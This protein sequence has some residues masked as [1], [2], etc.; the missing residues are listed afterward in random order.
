M[1]W[2]MHILH[3][4]QDWLLEE[5]IKD[6]RR[7]KIL[8]EPLPAHWDEYLQGNVAFYSR[9][10]PDNQKQLHD[11]L[12]VFAAERRWEGCGGLSITD[13]IKVT[14]AAQAC[15]L[16]LGMVHDYFSQVSSILVY[17]SGFLIDDAYSVRPGVI[18]EEGVAAIG[19][20]WHRGP[21]VLAWDAV[22][23]NGRDL[24]AGRNVVY[25]EFAHQLDFQGEW[26]HKTSRAEMA[27]LGKHWN[28]VMRREFERLV[29]A[30]EEGRA[31]LLDK[32]G[33]ASPA[34]F[35][36]V[37][38]ECFFCNP[39]GLKLRHPRLYELLGDFYGQDPAKWYQRAPEL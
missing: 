4:V 33:T 6:R 10:P 3:T 23:A 1:S 16:L 25:H 26:P 18:H 36:A 5:P 38:T 7:A 9:L 35:F 22:L 37:A 11:T 32:Y 29:R 24:K 30:S 2:W 14:I 17:P 12:R 28:W 27:A 21:V 8:Q 39:I 34:E 13:E 15:L 19:Q 20:A 31:T